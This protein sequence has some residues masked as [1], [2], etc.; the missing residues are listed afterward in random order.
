[1]RDT[2]EAVAARLSKLY[3]RAGRP[4]YRRLANALRDDHGVDVTPQTLIN[5]FTA[6][7]GCPDP[8]RM[9]AS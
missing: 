3:E 7:K 4:P 9:I 2:R 8:E 1:M 5:Y 6:S